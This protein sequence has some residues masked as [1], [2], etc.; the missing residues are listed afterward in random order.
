MKKR[1]VFATV[2]TIAVSMLFSSCGKKES[3]EVNFSFEKDID[4]RP[5]SNVE[6]KKDRDYLISENIKNLILNRTRKEKKIK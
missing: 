5:K 1:I 6:T 3:D 4:T 2:A